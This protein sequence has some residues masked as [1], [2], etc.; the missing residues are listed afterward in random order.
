MNYIVITDEEN[1]MIKGVY[2]G[3]AGLAPLLTASG[4]Y[5]FPEAC[6]TD[7]A[8]AEIS[9][10]LQPM[11]VN[12]QD[13]TKA[14]DVTDK[15]NTINWSSIQMTLTADDND[16]YA[17][18]TKYTLIT[19]FILSAGTYKATQLFYNNTDTFKT[20]KGSGDGFRKPIWL[21]A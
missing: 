5:I 16:L 18:L 3:Y 1:N 4:Y 8:F 14:S 2:K 7:P 15:E 13:I 9:D 11:I 19:Y 10:L 20:L 17:K 6:M 21:R 12:T